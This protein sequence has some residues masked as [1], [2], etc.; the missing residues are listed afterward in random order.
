VDGR[1]RESQRASG[2]AGVRRGLED[3]AYEEDEEE[4]TEARRETNRGTS[5]TIAATA[6]IAARPSS[7]ARPR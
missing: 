5:S 4:W 2:E 7:A 6:D 3:R 1:R